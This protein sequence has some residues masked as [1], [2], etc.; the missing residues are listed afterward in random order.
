MLTEN[1]Q[2]F[3][4]RKHFLILSFSIAYLLTGNKKWERIYNDFSTKV[5]PFHTTYY[6]IDMSGHF[7]RSRIF[8]IVT[9]TPKNIK[10]FTLFLANKRL[11]IQI[12]N[13][14]VDHIRPSLCDSNTSFL[15]L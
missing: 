10:R 14:I 11:E 2:L 4:V 7:R 5:E 1:L 13:L 15:S 6:Y 8:C 3:A 9:K 12:F